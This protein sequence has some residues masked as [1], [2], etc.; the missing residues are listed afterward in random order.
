[1]RKSL[2]LLFTA[3]AFV[4]G[5]FSVRAGTIQDFGLERFT[6]EQHARPEPILAEVPLSDTT[7]SPNFLPDSDAMVN[8][9]VLDSIRSLLRP[10]RGADAAWTQTPEYRP[11]ASLLLV[12]VALGTMGF[13]WRGGRAGE[14][15][16]RGAVRYVV[17]RRA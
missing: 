2:V 14:L 9:A 10:D 13:A 16:P 3:F 12:G 6:V 15:E 4:P 1:M 8:L 5:Q 7:A 17:R 11:W